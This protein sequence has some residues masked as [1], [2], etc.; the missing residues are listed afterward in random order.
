MK[1]V[2]KFRE[3]TEGEKKVFQLLLKESFSGRDELARQLAQCRV[4]EIDED[5]S[6]KI[7]VLGGPPARVMRR[8]PVEAYA[9]DEDGVTIHA[10]LHVLKGKATELEFYKDDSSR[11]R[12]QPDTWEILIL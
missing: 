2:R 5:G 7:R 12:R 6:L 11:I 3:P 10:L 1:N 9:N 8:I 4:R